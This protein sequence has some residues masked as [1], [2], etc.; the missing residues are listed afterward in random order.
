MANNGLDIRKRLQQWL[1]W[2]QP[3]KTQYYDYTCAKCGFVSDNAIDGIKVRHI[4]WLI[5]GRL[6]R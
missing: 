5:T 3:T 4:W 2:H 6:P 1:C